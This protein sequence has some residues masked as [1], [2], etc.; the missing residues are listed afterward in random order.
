MQ[1]NPKK[2]AFALAVAVLSNSSTQFTLLLIITLDIIYC[3]N[4]ALQ[5]LFTGY[6]QK[7]QN[8]TLRFHTG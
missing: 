4:A 1:H 6:E 2:D 8:K 5:Q 7:L 3:R